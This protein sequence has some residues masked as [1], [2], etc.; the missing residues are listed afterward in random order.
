M[1]D[2]LIYTQLHQCQQSKA[3]NLQPTIATSPAFS[4]TFDELIDAKRCSILRGECRAAY[5]NMIWNKNHQF[6]LFYQIQHWSIQLTHISTSQITLE[7]LQQKFDQ[8]YHFF[9]FNR[10]QKM[11]RKTARNWSIWMKRGNCTMIRASCQH[12]Y[13]GQLSKFQ[14]KT[15]GANQTVDNHLWVW[16]IWYK[17]DFEIWIS[18]Y[19]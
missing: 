9:P 17:E 6:T 13:C 11:E 8:N 19:W 1:I 18:K 4:S 3:T 16:L 12:I 7:R 2:I 5:W 10:Y 15:D 14:L